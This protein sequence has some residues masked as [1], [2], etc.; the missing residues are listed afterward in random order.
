MEEVPSV[1]KENIHTEEEDFQAFK[2]S[3]PGL[4]KRISELNGHLKREETG[5]EKKPRHVEFRRA[6]GERREKERKR[7]EI[8]SRLVS[9]TLLNG[10]GVRGLQIGK[11]VWGC[12]REEREERR[13]RFIEAGMEKTG[14]MS[15]EEER[16]EEFYLGYPN[17]GKAV[18]VKMYS[19]KAFAARCSQEGGKGVMRFSSF[20]RRGIDDDIDTDEEQVEEEFTRVFEGLK[21]EALKRFK[22]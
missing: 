12:E 18:R 4:M 21:A 17:K 7:K 10:P 5:S 6:E 19:D 3:M 16:E 11:R 13:E 14:F 22:C 9:D 8:K 2:D 15:V 20:K 1:G